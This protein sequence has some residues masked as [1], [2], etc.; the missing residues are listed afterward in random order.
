M[1]GVIGD[2]GRRPEDE[3]E[4]DKYYQASQRTGER[5]SR[6]GELAQFESSDECA[7]ES[8]DCS[9]GSDAEDVNV[10]GDAGEAGL[11]CR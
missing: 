1:S 7:G 11:P 9:G 5:F 3:V 4:P 2:A 8:E 6:Y 10:P